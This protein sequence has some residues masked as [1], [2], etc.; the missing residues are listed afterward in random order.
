MNR[1]VSIIIPVYNTEPNL[2]KKSLESAI[3]QSYSHIEIIVIDDG[4]NSRTTISLL[5]KYE[6]TNKI[7]LL[8][9]KNSG[10]S[11][12]RNQGLKQST[13]D[14]VLFLDSDDYID[15]NYTERLMDVAK[16]KNADIVFSG[17]VKTD[18]E[19]NDS[20]FKNR[21]INL[22][23]DSNCIVIKAHAFTSQGALIRGVKARSTRFTATTTTT[24]EDTEYMV[25]AMHGSKS[26]FDGRGG[27]HYVCNENSIT[28]ELSEKSIKKY[29]NETTLLCE[30]F[31]EILPADKTTLDIFK[32]LKLS[33]AIR[34][35]SIL[36]L[37]VKRANT[38][39]NDFM[40][41]AHIDDIPSQKILNEVW[42][43]KKE[44]AKIILLNDRKISTLYLLQ[45]INTA[46]KERK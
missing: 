25:K 11:V 5:E 17:K 4:S 16:K 6:R 10:V 15:S 31:R 43:S 26:Y 9:Q 39:A 18:T 1:L 2:L 8:K 29:L 20:P 41:K 24:G 7:I 36:K 12:A 32:L 37:G 44:K 21:I 46:I 14:Y 22:K 35:M 33:R 27:Y 40:L 45:K 19:E 13:G 30:A 42:L 38:I 23:S 28:H 34:K 3:N